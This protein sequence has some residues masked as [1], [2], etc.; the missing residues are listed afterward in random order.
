MVF[1]EYTPHCPDGVAE[2]KITVSSGL[3]DQNGKMC[4]EALA[5]VMETVTK[6]QLEKHGWSRIALQEKNTAW[7]MGWT[8]IQIKRLP[9]CGESLLLRT[10]P[11]QN[12][13]S[14]HVQKYAFYTASGEALVSTASLYLLMDRESRKM[15]SAGTELKSPAVKIPG[16]SAAP[17]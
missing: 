3:T 11:G 16:E 8:S 4:P 5:R 17:K 9:C 10:W 15:I 12:K 13:F 14:M 2:R 6:R 1:P 7:V